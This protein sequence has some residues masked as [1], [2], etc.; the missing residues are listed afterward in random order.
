MLSKLINLVWS[1][2][3]AYTAGVGAGKCR[4][5]RRTWTWGRRERQGATIG[6]GCA[7]CTS[8]ADREREDNAGAP[9]GGGAGGAGVRDGSC[10]V[11]G[12]YGAR[13]QRGGKAGTGGEDP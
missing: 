3:L 12:R 2:S 6:R 13:A 7:G 9:G 8:W 11:G 1:G 10:G 4:P 5:F